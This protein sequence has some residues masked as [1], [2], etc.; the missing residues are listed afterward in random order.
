MARTS[1]DAPDVTDVEMEA[2]H[3]VELGLEWLQRANGMLVSFHHA[4]GHAMD[5]LDD[6]ERTLRACG[7]DEFADELRD[8]LLPSGAVDERWTYDLLETFQSG[9]L[10]EATGFERRV[11]DDIADGHSHVAERQQEREWRRRAREPDE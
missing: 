11:R 6:A 9:L 10:N 8:D 4:T 2:L 5:H 3:A 7:H 1:D